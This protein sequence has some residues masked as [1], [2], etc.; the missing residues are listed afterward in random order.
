MLPLRHSGT[1]EL[2]ALSGAIGHDEGEKASRSERK[3]QNSLFPGEVIST[4]KTLM[5]LQ[6]ASRINKLFFYKPAMN[7]LTLK[8]K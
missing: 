4:W 6:H 7:T 1:A 8:L 3:K 2:G 5:N